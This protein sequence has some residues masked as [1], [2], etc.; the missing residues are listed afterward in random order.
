[1]TG[2]AIADRDWVVVRCQPDAENGSIVAAMLD[3]DTADGAEAT[4]KTLHKEDG[5]V[6]LIPQNPAYTPIPGDHA[7]IIGK[8]VTVLRRV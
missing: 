4:V 3:S 6:W 1:M 5:H 2:A 7:T 8:V